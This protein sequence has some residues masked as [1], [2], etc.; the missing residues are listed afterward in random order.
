MRI[1]HLIQSRV[2]GRANLQRLPARSMIHLKRFLARSS[3]PKGLCFLGLNL[4]GAFG[5]WSLKLRSRR[6]LGK[7]ARRGFG[8][9][10]DGRG[11]GGDDSSTFTWVGKSKWMSHSLGSRSF[12]GLKLVATG[13]LTQFFF[14][15]LFGCIPFF[16]LL[17]PPEEKYF[18]Q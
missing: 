12:R 4:G 16:H 9:P 1:L 7:R 6:A 3:G 18:Q 15:C 13:P 10:S 2:E 11:R 14:F 8:N 17:K 5:L